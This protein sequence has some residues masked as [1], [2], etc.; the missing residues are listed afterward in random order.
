ML[1]TVNEATPPLDAQTFS[2]PCSAAL[3]ASGTVGKNGP[4]WVVWA[5]A[6]VEV[7]A[8]AAHIAKVV[9]RAFG[10]VFSPWAKWPQAPT[11]KTGASA[12]TVG[13]LR[14]ADAMRLPDTIRCGPGRTFVAQTKSFAPSQSLSRARATHDERSPGSRVTIR[15]HNLPRKSQ[16]FGPLRNPCTSNSPLTVAGTVPE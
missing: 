10:M 7:R 4:T 14:Q 8:R 3:I 9:Y 15:S 2:T 5:L 1:R 16:W 6:T 12:R 11:N 13:P